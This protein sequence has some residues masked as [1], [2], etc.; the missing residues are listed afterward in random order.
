MKKISRPSALGA[1]TVL[2]ALLVLGTQMPGEWRDEAFRVT[3]LPWQLT[4]VAHFVLFACLA[5]VAHLPPLA[6]SRV[7]VLVAALA[8]A[9]LTEGLQH[10]AVHRDPSW[11]DVGTDMA[12]AALGVMLA[13]RVVALTS[14]P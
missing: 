7:R 5:C 12:G 3:H 2:L 1:L 14:S 13:W 10:F 6:W 11:F 8:L 4:K 9:L